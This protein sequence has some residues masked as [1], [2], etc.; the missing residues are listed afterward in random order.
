MGRALQASG[1]RALPARAAARWAEKESSYIHSAISKLGELGYFQVDPRS[2]AELGI[3]LRD[4]RRM[5]LTPHGSARLSALHADALL[6]RA[7]AVSSSR[8]ICAFL[9]K[10]EHS[11]PILS[12]V[13]LRDG[14]VESIA[15]CAARVSA[16]AARGEFRLPSKDW[17][18]TYG[19]YLASAYYVATGSTHGYAAVTPGRAIVPAGAR[20]CTHVRKG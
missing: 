2:L 8:D 11:L 10:L 5:V 14:M 1:L 15:E 17:T 3:T 19:K 13:V 6:S 20:A 9:A 7:E 18:P 4:A 12:R 16:A